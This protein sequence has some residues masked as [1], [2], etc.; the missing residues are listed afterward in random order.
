ML[1]WN[2]CYLLDGGMGTM[3]QARG[4][5]PGANPEKLNLERPEVVRGVHAAY[6][7]AGAQIVTTNPGWYPPGQGG[8]R[9]AGGPG[10]GPPGRHAGAYGPHAL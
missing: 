1:D 2:R 6:L 4:L 10:R 9:G 5:R 3:L 8:R 7:E